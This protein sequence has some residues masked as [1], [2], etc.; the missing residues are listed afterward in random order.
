MAGGQP[1]LSAQRGL[2]YEVK[3]A[4]LF[5]FVQF[6]E[7]PP[8]TFADPSTPFLICLYGDDPFGTM[9]A[10]TVEG[11]QVGPHPIRIERVATDAPPSRCQLLF[12]PQSQS[13][14]AASALRAADGPMLTVGESPAFLSAGG[15][16]NMFVD[17]GHVRFEVNITAA[18]AKRLNLSSKLLR[19]ARNTSD[20]GGR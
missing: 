1:S 14:R 6:I 20:I 10:R 16:I 15:I 9:L 5:N 17:G 7:W 12:V 13:G 18:N 3:A 19:L 8:E 2:E 11:E 4:F